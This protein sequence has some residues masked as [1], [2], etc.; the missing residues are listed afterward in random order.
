[1]CTAPMAYSHNGRAPKRPST[2][3]AT[4]PFQSAAV[5]IVHSGV[6]RCTDRYRATPLTVVLSRVCDDG[7]HVIA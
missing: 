2:K 5:L 1:M 6:A 7:I 4:R 3:K